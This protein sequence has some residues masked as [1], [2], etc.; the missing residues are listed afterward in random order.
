MK[1]SEIEEAVSSIRCNLKH[2]LEQPFLILVYPRHTK[3]VWT[4]LFVEGKI[5]EHDFPLIK[6][7]II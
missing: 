5:R 2:I 4:Y 6:K 3:A 1:V 7:Q